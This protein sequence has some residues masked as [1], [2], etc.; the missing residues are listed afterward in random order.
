MVPNE[1]NLHSELEVNTVK[2][3]IKLYSSNNNKLPKEAK[4]T[5][6]SWN[7]KYA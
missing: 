2:E 5:T 4:K 3:E 7:S 6:P 1:Y